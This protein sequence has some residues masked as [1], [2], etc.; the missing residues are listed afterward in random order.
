[1]KN[2]AENKRDIRT[3][4]NMEYCSPRSK[5]TPMK[6][7]Q[8]TNCLVA[9]PRRMLPFR[10]PDLCQRYGLTSPCQLSYHLT[11]VRASESHRPDH[12]NHLSGSQLS[13]MLQPR[14]PVTAST[15]AKTHERSPSISHDKSPHPK[16]DLSTHSRSAHIRREHKSMAASD[17]GKS[18]TVQRLHSTKERL[19]TPL[20]GKSIPAVSLER[21]LQK[22]RRESEDSDASVKKSCVR[23]E[24]PKPPPKSP[25]RTSPGVTEETE[26]PNERSTCLHSL[27]KSKPVQ[28]PCTPSKPSVTPKTFLGARQLQIYSTHGNIIQLGF[29]C[30]NNGDVFKKASERCDKSEKVKA[31]V[32]PN[33]I[34]NAPHLSPPRQPQH[35]S[36][37]SPVRTLKRKSRNVPC[38]SPSKSNRSLSTPP[39]KR[40]K[41]HHRRRTVPNDYDELFTPDVILSPV[42][43]ANKTK[44][45]ETEEETEKKTPGCSSAI[46]SSENSFSKGENSGSTCSIKFPISSK[47]L[48]ISSPYVSLVRLDIKDIESFY[49]TGGK[50]QNWADFSSRGHRTHDGLKH[51]EENKARKCSSSRR[52]RSPPVKSREGQRPHTDEAESVDEDLDLSLGIAFDL[53]SSQTSKS[54]EEEQLLSLKEIMNHFPT[55]PATPDKDAALSEP[56]TPGG[57]SQALKAQPTIRRDSYRNNLDQM[58]KEIDT[59]KKA[60]ENEAQLRTLCD[61]ELLGVAEYHEE[62]NRDEGCSE[63]EEFLQ[64]YSL[65]HSVI[66]DVPPGEVV[67][68]LD[69]FG[70]IFNQDS[71]QLRQCN[72]K[73][74]SPKQKILLWSSPA[75]LKLHVKIRLFQ[76][77]YYGS[78]SPC[79]TQIT[80][81]L[82]KMMSVHSERILSE[83]ILQALCD[84]ARSAASNI[85]KKKSSAFTVWVPALADLTLVLMNMGVAFVTLFPFENLQPAFTEGDLLKNVYIQSE[86]PPRT[87]EWNAFPEHNCNNIIKYLSYC[88]GMC[89]K[90]YSDYELLLLLTVTARVALDTHFIPLAGVAVNELLNK[91]VSNIRDWDT[92]LP[93]LCRILTDLTDDHHNMCLLVQLLPVDARGKCLRQHL[94]LSMISKLL[95]GTSRYQPSGKEIELATLK[96]YVPAMQPSSL[97]RFILNT[98][99]RSSTEEDVTFLDQQSYYLCHSLLTLT[100]VASDFQVFPTHQKEHLLTLSSDLRSH[101]ICH[102]RES[103]KCLYRSKVKDLLARIYTKW[104][105]IHQRMQPLHSKVCDYWKP[106]SAGTLTC[107]RK[108]SDHSRGRRT[109]SEDAAEVKGEATSEQEEAPSAHRTNSNQPGW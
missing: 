1:M 83:K 27:P 58:L 5:E 64:R 31:E 71:L 96:P 73:P 87:R 40:N 48:N 32:P 42:H 63:R 41:L 53:E 3:L 77:A 44:T 34:I 4:K 14:L 33:N 80:N 16:K 25:P 108:E 49:S 52:S 81:F 102:I 104:Q 47:R 19:S 92:M 7:S 17:S 20:S 2:G 15:V 68:H 99:G 75:Q 38:K 70:Q 39:A 98:S 69:K 94:S 22:R 95:D 91:I 51:D 76:E 54:S 35:I 30:N 10:S 74:Q 88:M 78:Q 8:I 46:K 9:P 11:P 29:L 93:R 101:V 105:M 57:P 36:S 56:S 60:K 86:C 84:I 72:V 6:P 100:N 67:F 45:G 23:V 18:G 26:T 37:E 13:P 103:E 109:G 107:G 97:R 65:E 59:Q 82:F 12:A 55:I 62:E 85:V 106:S 24:P 66:R 89:P 50:S 43:N 79:P 21:P 28:S 61:E 90:A